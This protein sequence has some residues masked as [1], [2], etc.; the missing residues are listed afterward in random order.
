[1]ALARLLGFDLC[2]RLKELKQRHLY[3]PRGT[4]IPPE[5]AAVCEANV[6][7]ALI[8][9]H[10]DTWGLFVFVVKTDGRKPSTGVGVVA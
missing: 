5:I 6:D 9:K 3:V 7:P 2:P 1:M 4:V 10:W 8:G